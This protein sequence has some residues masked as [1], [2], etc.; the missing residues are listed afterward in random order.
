MPVYASHL[1]GGSHVHTLTAVALAGLVRFGVYACAC[2]YQDNALHVLLEGGAA[3]MTAA[4][5]LYSLCLMHSAAWSLTQ[6][7]EQALPWF[8]P[9]SGHAKARHRLKVSGLV[10]AGAGYYRLREVGA[11]FWGAGLLSLASVGVLLWSLRLH[12]HHGVRGV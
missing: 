9:A 6:L 1:L 12:S 10:L 8:L 11:L 2:L 7:V 3:S 4:A 5:W